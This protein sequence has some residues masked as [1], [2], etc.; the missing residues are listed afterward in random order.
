MSILLLLYI[1]VYFRLFEQSD[2]RT[3]VTMIYDFSKQFFFYYISS[4]F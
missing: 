2:E 1:H 3:D 4:P